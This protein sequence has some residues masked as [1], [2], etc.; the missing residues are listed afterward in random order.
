MTNNRNTPESRK[1]AK[2]RYFQK[3]YDNAIVVKCACGCGTDIKNKD[4]YGRNKKYV[5][6]HNNKKYDDPTQYKRE[7]NHRNRDQRYA[8]KV[9]RAHDIKI[10]FIRQKGN[11]CEQCGTEYNGNNSCIFDLHHKDPTKKEFS[12]SQQ[13][14]AN[15]KLANIKLELEKCSLLC[16]NCHRLLHFGGW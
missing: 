13:S 10:S 9:Q 5:N 4:Q 11:K 6:G 14:L 8:Y 2:E 16:S 7:W 15:N 1:K 3:V 12:L